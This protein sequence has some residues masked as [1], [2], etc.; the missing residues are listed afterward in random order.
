MTTQ[1]PDL[2]TIISTISILVAILI[3]FVVVVV[4]AAN[5]PRGRGK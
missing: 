2:P 4:D 1:Q 5:H 3:V